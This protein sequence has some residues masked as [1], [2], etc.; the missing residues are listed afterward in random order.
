[1]IDSMKTPRA[2]VVPAT[3]PPPESVPENDC[4][5]LVIGGGPAGST[6]AALLAAQGR[7]VVLLEKAHHPRFHIGESLLPANVALFEQLGVLEQV[8]RIGIHKFGIE[9]VSPDHEHRSHLDYSEAW[10]KTRP[11]A[12]Q[13]RRSELDELLFR[14]AAARGARTV[15]GC[16]VREVTFDTEGATVGTEL[17]D[18][19]KRSWRARFIVDA[20]GR[21]TFLA[22]K[23]KCK[24]KNP[25]HNTSALFGHY[26]GARRLPGLQEGNIS[27]MWF[28]HGWFWFIPLADGTTSVG[29]VCWPYYLKSRDKSVPQF[30]DDT[31]AL[32]PELADRLKGATRVD[33]A[34]HAT[35][36]YSYSSTQSS[37]DRYLLLGDAFTFIDPMFSS[38]VYLAMQG[39]FD[40]V[41][42]VAARLDHPG[43]AAKARRRFDARMRRGPREFSWFI[44]RVTN[45][46][47]RHLFMYPANPLRVKEALM[48]LL[49]GDVFGRSP[50]QPSLWV[51]KG[52]YYLIS[53]RNL[54]RSIRGW[55]QRGN[56]IRDMGP[57]VGENVLDLE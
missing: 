9:F 4:D 11:Y 52:I 46:T 10:D 28:R 26:T 23:L 37:G 31:I 32:C 16:R 36:N 33:D 50:I 7:D 19:A 6:I 44:F 43:A 49:A 25:R 8:E 3:A 5:V 53:I 39:A 29:V 2:P 20:S 40:G 38:G 27:L 34:V 21:D 12:W 51:L 30:F 47:I 13:V 1:M 56:N 45:P 41:D 15:E 17:D 48:A 55:R 54:R 18:G 22:S 42:V 24:E 14:N 35:G 57:L